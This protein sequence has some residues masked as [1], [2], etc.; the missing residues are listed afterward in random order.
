MNS[1]KHKIQAFTLSELVVVM[2]ITVIVVGIAFSVLQL[3]QKQLYGIQTNFG[4][5]TNVRLL[6]QSLYIDMHRSNL[7][8]YDEVNNKLHFISEIDT[9]SYQFE[10]DY[11]HKVTDTF[12]V[13]VRDMK[14]FFEGIETNTAKIDAFKLTT[15]KEFRKATIFIFKRNTANTFMNP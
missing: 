5:I 14:L 6:E 12:N 9:V 8:Q 15:S 10:K 13:A 4:N 11:V 7:I 1:D 2:L 3:V